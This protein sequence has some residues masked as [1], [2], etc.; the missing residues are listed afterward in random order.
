MSIDM[1]CGE[2]PD[3]LVVR[4]ASQR[5]V[6]RL[7]GNDDCRTLAE[8]VEESSVQSFRTAGDCPDLTHRRMQQ[9]PTVS[10]HA[11]TRD[12]R[13]EVPAVELSAAGVVFTDRLWRSHLRV[14][15][16]TLPPGQWIAF[17]STEG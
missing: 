3:G 9:E 2:F 16:I 17:E 13:T 11:E 10:R 8:D 15:S 6:G 7:N 1:V 4:T 12:D 14:H 5:V